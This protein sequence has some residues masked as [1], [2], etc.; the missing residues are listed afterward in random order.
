MQVDRESRYDYVDLL[1]GIGIWLVVWGHSMAPRSIYIYSFHMPLFFFLSGY[2]HKD[3]PFGQFVVRK[4]NTLYIPYAVFTLGSWLFYLVRHLIH[5]QQE[6]LPDHFWK[7][8]SLIT[9]TANNGGNNPIWFLTCLLM[10]SILFLILRRV[11]PNSTALG[12]AVLSSSS[13]GYGLSLVDIHL[14]FNLDIAF[15]GLVFYYWGFVVKQKGFLEQL[16]RWP[17]FRW[18]GL[19]VIGEILHIMTAFLN[20]GISGI[21]WV[22][23]AGN[24]L[25]DYLLFYLSAGFGIFTFLSFGYFIQKISF[26][27]YLGKNSLIILAVH[28]PLLL[29]L[30]EYFLQFLDTGAIYYGLLL[31]VLTV[32]L[33]VPVIWLVNARFPWMIGK[34]P[35]FREPRPAER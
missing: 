19:V 14:Y 16:D 34:R 18:I 9:G 27:N 35:V 8:T 12:W 6:V 32:L 24:T 4:L 21:G 30:N 25:G 7:L 10:V 13:I 11:F 15:S 5:Q 28:K 22:N 33:I 17:K 23:M 3:K 1:K 2:L 20:P 26:L 29:L 31:S